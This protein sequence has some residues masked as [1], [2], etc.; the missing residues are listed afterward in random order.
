MTPLFKHIL[1][2]AL[3]LTIGCLNA[4][5]LHFSQFMNAPLLTNPANT[6]F[7][8][9]ADYRLGANFRQQWASVPVPFKTYSI[10][11]DAQVFRNQFE[12]GWLGLGGSIFSDVAGRGNL[13]TTKIMGNIAYHQMLGEHSLV[14]AG[15]TGGLVVKRINPTVFTWD[16][17]WNGKFFNGALPT[18]E[19][20]SNNVTRYAD[21]G[22]GLNYAYFPTENL[23]YNAGFSV[24]HANQPSE[25]FFSNNTTANYDAK[26][27]PRYTFFAN[28]SFKLNNNV[29]V[30][31]NVYIS[32]QSRASE[33][34]LGGTVN[35]NLKQ[36]A[37]DN[38]ELFGG[39]YYRINDAIVP[40]VGVLYK[41][42]RL[43]VSYD[44]TLSNNLASFNKLRGGNELNLTRLGFYNTT[45]KD[46]RKVGCFSPAF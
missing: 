15:F 7:L 46:T 34:V 28:G 42:I 24:A 2:I 35:Y 1:T 43:A 27:K 11:G 20:F 5:D 18:G 33:I 9:N 16:N 4:Q 39:L 21:I 44:F 45:N 38:T 23:Y 25:S 30:N 3:A 17:Q 6:G 40:T 32:T 37:T 41:N 36:N 12:N 22:F 29:I 19:T 8:P 26:V 13:T 10:W 14:S 31:P